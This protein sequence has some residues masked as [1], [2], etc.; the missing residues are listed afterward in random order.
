MGPVRLSDVF[1]I[2]SGIIALLVC[3]MAVGAFW[4]VER[5][6]NKFGDPETLPAGGAR[7]KTSAAIVLVTLGLI[8][9]VVNPDKYQINKQINKADPDKPAAVVPAGKAAPPAE[10]FK[11]VNDEGC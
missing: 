11:I 4:L 2:Q 3:V 1:G 10:G 9:A 6:E 5:V 8:L 7:L